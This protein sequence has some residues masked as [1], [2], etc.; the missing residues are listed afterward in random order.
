MTNT[1]AA[2]HTPTPWGLCGESRGGCLCGQIWAV[3]A[4]HPV[5]TV[6]SGKW[7]DTFPTLKIT[8]TS[9]DRKAEAVI[10]M[11]EYGE[12]GEDV[13]KANAALIVRAVNCH[14]ELVAALEKAA[15]QFSRL[16]YVD[17]EK[18]YRAILAKVQS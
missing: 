15:N 16:G 1:I 4:D 3:G 13:A 18:Y 10:E 7:G 8:G 12:V 14:E 11:I 2:K 5:A 17:S 9:I 6:I